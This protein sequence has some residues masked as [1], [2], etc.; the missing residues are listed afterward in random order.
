[1]NRITQHS[2]RF[3]QIWTSTN[4]QFRRDQ[5]KITEEKEKPKLLLPILENVWRQIARRLNK[6]ALQGK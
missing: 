1:M 6:K 4:Y 2:I 3:H 5:S